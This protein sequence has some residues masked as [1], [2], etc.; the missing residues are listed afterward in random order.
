M[1]TQNNDR[2]TIVHTR[3]VSSLLSS[4]LLATIIFAHVGAASTWATVDPTLQAIANRVT[5]SVGEVITTTPRHSSG[6]VFVF[7]EYHNSRAGQVQIATTLTRLYQQLGLRIVG[8][9][10]AVKGPAPLPTEKYLKAADPTT[11][12]DV[13]KDLLREAEISGVEYAGA[14]LHG[15][16]VVG[17]ENPDEYGVQPVDSA[18]EFRA[19]LFVAERTLNST[20][21]EKVGEKL[22]AD[23][24]EEALEIMKAAD[25]WIKARLDGLKSSDPNF[26]SV[27]NTQAI[28]DKTKSL[29]ISL[30]ADVTRGLEADI[31]FHHIAEKR[32]DTMADAV[33]ELA[34]QNA[35][36]PVAMI[37][38]AAHTKRVLA[39]LEKKGATT[40]VL[41]PRDFKG[42]DDGISLRR[43]RLKSQG[44][45]GNDDPNSLGALLNPKRKPAPVI[46]NMKRDGYASA[47]AAAKIAAKSVR[48]GGDFPKAIIDQLKALPGIT[49]DPLSF[50]KKGYDVIFS[51]DIENNGK[52]QKI[53]VRAGTR[54]TGTQ[55]SSDPLEAAL[56]E[57]KKA[58]ADGG[59][60]GGKEPPKKTK[61]AAVDNPDGGKKGE[62]EGKGDNKTST[63]KPET[64]GLLT[65]R[66]VQAKFFTSVEEARSHAPISL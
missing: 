58:E 31:H 34:N 59:S 48:S 33:A 27:A 55:S 41:R 63:S 54:P 47:Q 38:G 14:V 57:L 49:V 11:R 29:N 24:I 12:R 36:K 60:G 50:E 26:D 21:L 43:F 37:I 9:E 52:T 45:W 23:K 22:K 62:N 40:V 32:S 7:E 35:G 5:N 44:L 51:L 53:W 64:A 28:L 39:E 10:G 1:K 13:L 61:D 2:V 16:Q 25:P 19:I 66:E 56:S 15:L 42:E 30:P 8:L 65:N 18:A 20:E 3:F 4:R 46:G 6:P 17:I